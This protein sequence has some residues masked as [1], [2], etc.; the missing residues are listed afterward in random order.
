MELP[1]QG[2]CLQ[3]IQKLWDYKCCC[4]TEDHKI[5]CMEAG[6]ACKAGL[7]LLKQR[8]TT[9]GISMPEMDDEKH[10]FAGLDIGVGRF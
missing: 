2:I 9:A 5:V 6:R 3:V 8:S 7:K 10:T 4:G 1:I